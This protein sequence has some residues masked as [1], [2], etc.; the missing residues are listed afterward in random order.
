M[1]RSV[2]ELGAQ[3]QPLSGLAAQVGAALEPCGGTVPLVAHPVP[4]AGDHPQAAEHVPPAALRQDALCPAGSRGLHPG[5]QQLLLHHS[6]PV[7]PGG[8]GTPPS[9][10]PGPGRA[11]GCC[12]PW[13]GAQQPQH[14]QRVPQG[15]RGAVAG[16][17]GGWCKLKVTCAAGVT[18]S[19]CR[20]SPLDYPWRIWLARILLDLGLSGCLS[21]G[22]VH[23]IVLLAVLHTALMCLI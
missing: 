23:R 8:W 3:S 9:L 4:S 1:I 13:Q 16:R 18:V 5:Q 14:L 12:S 19:S 6:V 21:K 22:R 11:G 20:A 7:S 10:F 17:G 15:H 2:P